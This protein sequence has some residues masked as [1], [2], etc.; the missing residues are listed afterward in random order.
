M[1]YMFNHAKAF[2]NQNLSSWNVGNV[3]SY[4]Q[5]SFM[6]GSGGGNTEPNWNK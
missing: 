3:P 5:G 6:D 1:G 4:Q 2:K